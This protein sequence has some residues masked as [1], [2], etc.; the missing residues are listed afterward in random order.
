M[1]S[2]HA[3]QLRRAIENLINVKLTDALCTPGGLDRLRA[4]RITGVVSPTIRMAQRELERTLGE[5]IESSHLDANPEQ[6]GV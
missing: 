4:H 5:M 6:V 3:Q 2:T 1:S